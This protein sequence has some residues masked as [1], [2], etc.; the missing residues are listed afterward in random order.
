MPRRASPR[1]F[2]VSLEAKPESI[3]SSSNR[4]LALFIRKLTRH[5]L[6]AVDF[7]QNLAMMRLKHVFRSE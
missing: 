3:F 4:L 6:I 2:F 1:L 5:S 7:I